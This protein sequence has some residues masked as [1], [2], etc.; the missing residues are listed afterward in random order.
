[1]L[2][3]YSNTPDSTNQLVTKHL[4]KLKVLGNEFTI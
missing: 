4:N 1:M 3:L 2:S